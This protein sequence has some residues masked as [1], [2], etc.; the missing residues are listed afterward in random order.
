MIVALLDV[1]FVH[2][3]LLVECCNC[4]LLLGLVTNACIRLG[5]SGHEVHFY[6]SNDLLSG[7]ALELMRD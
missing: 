3:K 2:Q 4:G 5:T 1:L 6:V 7:R